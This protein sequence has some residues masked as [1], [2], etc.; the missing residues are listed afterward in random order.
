MCAVN[1]EGSERSSSRIVLNDESISSSA[2]SSDSYSLLHSS[3]RNNLVAITDGMIW[4]TFEWVSPAWG[5]E[6]KWNI[7][8]YISGKK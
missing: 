6:S 3:G 8:D 2:V 5:G 7:H 4:T 1:L